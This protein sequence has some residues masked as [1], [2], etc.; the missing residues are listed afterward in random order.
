MCTR[1][2][3]RC[4]K[5]LTVTASCI[6]MPSAWVCACGSEEPYAAELEHASGHHPDFKNREAESVAGLQ[7]LGSQSGG[8]G[9]HLLVRMGAFDCKLQQRGSRK[10]DVHGVQ[11]CPPLLWQ[12]ILS[13]R[14]G[15]LS[16]QMVTLE[17]VFTWS[18]DKM[19]WRASFNSL[20]SQPADFANAIAE[21]PGNKI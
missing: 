17:L 12:S 18:S 15:L 13:E 19:H 7:H 3:P 8:M 5:T 2:P 11:T 14:A 9:S 4:P 21:T 6:A 10:Q 1:R 16:S 20:V